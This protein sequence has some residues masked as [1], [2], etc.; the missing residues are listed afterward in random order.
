[1]CVS[2]TVEEAAWLGWRLPAWGP[3]DSGSRALL[4]AVLA[5]VMEGPGPFCALESCIFS[6]WDCSM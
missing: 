3:A 5:A 1:M 6:D 2:S 4:L